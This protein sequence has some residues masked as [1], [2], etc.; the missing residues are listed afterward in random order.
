MRREPEP[1]IVHLKCTECGHEQDVTS[2]CGEYVDGEP[3]Y[4]FGSS[5]NFCDSCDHEVNPVIP[6]ELT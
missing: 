2:V 3:V 4:W 6:K 1:K 5:Y